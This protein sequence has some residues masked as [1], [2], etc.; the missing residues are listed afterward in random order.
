MRWDGLQFTKGGGIWTKAGSTT[1][2][3]TDHVVPLSEPA[4]QLLTA[5]KRDA[6]GE[7]VFP[8]DSAAGHIVD[9]KKGWAALLDRAGIKGLRLHDLRHSYASQLASSGASLELIGALLDIHHLSRRRAIRIFSIRCSARPR[10][11]SAG[12]SV[13]P[14]EATP[15][16]NDWFATEYVI[17][18]LDDIR[19]RLKAGAQGP[20]AI[21]DADECVKVL[22]AL[23]DPAYPNSR[24]PA[25]AVREYSIYA[26][27]M[28]LKRAG[29]RRKP[30]LPKQ[31]NIP[32]VQSRR[33]AL[34]SRSTNKSETFLVQLFRLDGS[35]RANKSETFSF[36]ILLLSCHL[37][38]IK[39]AVHF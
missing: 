35:R 2:Q 19:K 30:P 37:V 27:Y 34:S 18:V 11:V 22:G 6:G 21:L 28:K 16:A 17:E 24:P 10:S 38:I 39:Q 8:S 23:V 15:M 36:F 33:F 4:C 1:K 20:G 14:M 31:L 3:K 26:F 5:I 7:F 13:T 12:S 29:M 25:D 9:I 32:A